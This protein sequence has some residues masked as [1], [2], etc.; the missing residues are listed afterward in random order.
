MSSPKKQKPKILVVDDEPDNL[1]LLYRTFHRGYKVFRACSGTEALDILTQQ[2]DVA[3]IISD[4]RMPQMSGTEF[5]SIASE[6]YPD[7]IRILLTGYTD[8]E[9]LV[10]AINAG[11]VFKYVTKPWDA[12]ELTAIVQQALDT[13]NVLKARTEE[14]R[15]ALKQESLLYAV[16]NTIRSAPNYHTMLQRIVETVGQMF[17]VSYC[18]LQPFQDGS[19]VDEWF[20]Y[21]GPELDHDPLQTQ[22]TEFKTL[23]WETTDVL[24]ID[25]A[26]T[27]ESLQ[28]GRE[29]HQQRAAA[30]R[31]ADIHSSLIVPLFYR[32]ELMAVLA[33]HQA[34]QPRTWLDHEVQLV[35]TVADQAALAL[36]QARSY[37]QVQALAK[38]EVLVNT[39]TAAIRRSLD[40][41]K[42]FAAITQQL[43]QALQVDG[44][45]LS[46]WT[47]EDEFVQCVGLYEAS[48]DTPMINPIIE[49]EVEEVS[50][51]PP[52]YLPQSAVPIRGN[53]VLKQLLDTQQ[54]VVIDDLSQQPQFNPIDLPL[55]SP[56]SALMVMPLNLDGEI[57]G[58]ISLRQNHT[59]RRWQEAEINLVQLVA[60]QAALAVQQARLYQKT[61][62]QA[63][64]LLEVDRLKTEFFQNVSHEFRTPLTLMIGPLES[65]VNQLDDLPYAQ[66]KIALRNSRRLL[67]LVNQLLD[68]QRFDA[69]RMQPSFR[70][71]DL[72]LFCQQTVEAFQTYCEKKGINLATHF[73][74]CPPVYLDLERFDKVLYNLLSNAMKFTPAEGTIT[75]SVESAGSYCRLQVKDSGIGIRPEQIPHLF[76]RFRQAEGS[77][78]RSYEG[79]GLGLALVKELVDLHQ[80]RISVDSVYGEGTTFVIWL[81]TGTAHLP[82]D[83]VLEVPAEL[84]ARRAAV[85]LADVEVEISE[86]ETVN[87][88]KSEPLEVVT[89]SESELIDNCILVVDDNPDLR[90]YVSRILRQVNFNVVTASNG[91]EGFAMAKR[92][93]P[94]VIITDLMMPLVSGLDLIRMIREQQD[95][96]G[97][98]IILLTAK[99]DEDTRIE[100]VER[101]ADAYVSKPFN[102]RELLAEVRNL[103]SLKENERRV[104]E[105]NRYLTESVLQ[106]FLP[107][108]MVK[109]AASGDLVLDLNPEPRVITILFTDLVGFTRLSNVLQAR[110][111]A[112]LLNEY[113]AEMTQAVFATGGTVDKF[114]GDAVM[115]IYGAPEELAPAQ[116]VKRA[117][118]AARQ[119]LRSLEELN[120]R[121]EK[122][123]I[124]DHK[125]VFPVRFRCGIH[126][127]SAVVGMFGAK[128]RS[129]YTAIG[130]SVNIASRL[131]EVAQPNSILVSDE[132]AQY[133]QPEEMTQSALLELKGMDEAVQAYQVRPEFPE[134]KD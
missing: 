1:D 96:K 10:E 94:E 30:Y 77:T 44:C 120:Q 103:R 66:A 31:A 24:V 86:D 82:G 67:R 12:L 101:G 25:E 63:E 48:Q 15:R 34:Y 76:E 11:K 20:I 80:G 43:G 124:I 50:A 99:A 128:E 4:Q 3:V 68:L 119:M 95:L 28:G 16:T 88:L 117:I 37:E 113:L 61:R 54:P 55:R 60:A 18:L 72:V 38:R 21:Q 116:Q 14:L 104:A 51:I 8:V 106:R 52:P 71:C 78:N 98:P 58:S 111:I 26:Q 56:S 131:Q 45:A 123:G 87:S 19:M 125:T 93:H 49:N 6:Q 90:Q 102:D 122:M 114:I 121:W 130:P 92:Y 134:A 108:Q 129:D 81:P 22:P 118:A 75:V 73:Q 42:I 57:I 7:A 79:S 17:E 110:R 132:V 13:H 53:P 41:Q 32:L 84:N 115:A 91:S 33:L 70:P 74:N 2:P 100:G 69:G 59:I 36:S 105:L 40:P 97:T 83:Q 85:E 107:P 35:I 65:A 23:V 5:L 64:R 126:Q 47:K 127:G 29:E 89:L 133:L 109:K 27:H 62:Q 9:D 46:L 39:I 112:E